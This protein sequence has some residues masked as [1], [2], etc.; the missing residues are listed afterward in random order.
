MSDETLGSLII[1][2]GVIVIIVAIA[3][4]VVHIVLGLL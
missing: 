4:V 2:V 1:V 3:T